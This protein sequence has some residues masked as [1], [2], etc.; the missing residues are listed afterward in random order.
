MNY[1]TELLSTASYLADKFA[2]VWLILTNQG[3]AYGLLALLIVGFLGTLIVIV[4]YSLEKDFY[5]DA[6]LGDALIIWTILRIIFVIIAFATICVWTTSLTLLYNPEYF[7]LD[8][9]LDRL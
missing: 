2:H 8:F 1:Y 3:M 6:D 5:S 4:T 7:A 9:L